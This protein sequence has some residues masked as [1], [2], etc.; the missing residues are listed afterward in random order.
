MVSDDR[1]H[2]ARG[3]DGRYTSGP[4]ATRRGLIEDA[5][6]RV[7]GSH[8][9]RARVQA[10]GRNGNRSQP[11]PVSLLPEHTREWEPDVEWIEE[12]LELMLGADPRGAA[13]ELDLELRLAAFERDLVLEDH[14]RA[15]DE[16]DRLSRLEI[17]RARNVARFP[18]S[19]NLRRARNSLFS[20]DPETEDPNQAVEP[21]EEGLD[22]DRVASNPAASGE[23]RRIATTTRI[24]EPG[25]EGRRSPARGRSSALHRRL[26]RARMRRRRKA[27]T[28]RE[29]RG[30]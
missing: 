15:R 7:K 18:D 19:R 6:T 14:A 11:R 10:Q 1:R 20:P 23:P 21:F 25:T 17:V 2:R 9:H 4:G 8:Q 28:R 27:R 13:E 12:R 30:G 24:I 22:A 26:R 29:E 3:E 16:A 5:T